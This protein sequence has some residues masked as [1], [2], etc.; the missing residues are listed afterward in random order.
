M[1]KS[2]WSRNLSWTWLVC[3]MKFYGIWFSAQFSVFILNMWVLNVKWF[4]VL[5]VAKTDR[6]STEIVYIHDDT[7]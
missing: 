1:L 5:R 6:E 4:K 2:Q 3:E 7:M